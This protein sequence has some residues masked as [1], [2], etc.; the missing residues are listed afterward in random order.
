MSAPLNPP[1]TANA[2]GEFSPR[3]HTTKPARLPRSLRS[4]F[5]TAPF[6][7]TAMATAFA[8]GPFLGAI[9]VQF[10]DPHHKEGVLAFITAISAVGAMVTQPLVGV[11]SDR[12]RGRWGARKP[13]IVAGAIVGIVALL[14]AGLAPS[15]A[16]LTLGI[17]GV[18]VGFNML[19]APFTALLPD[20]VP[21]RFRGRYSSLFGLGAVLG[22]TLGPVVG[23]AFVGQIFLGYLTVA[24]FV[25]LSVL[26]FVLLVP[27]RVKEETDEAV[28][29]HRRSKLKIRDVFAAFWVSPVKY[30]DFFW[31]FLNRI[32]LFSAVTMTSTYGLYILQEYIGLSLDAA[33]QLLALMGVISLPV[34]LVVTAVAGPLSDKVGRRKPIVLIAGILIFVGAALPMIVPNPVVF[35]V[36]GTLNTAG[37]AAFLSTDQA[38]VSQVL[39]PR[40][41]FGKDLGVLNIAATLPNVIAPVVAALIV[42]VFG[43][44]FALYPVVAIIGLAGALCVIPIRGAK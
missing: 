33:A 22:A 15:V 37:F 29:T 28:E 9:Q 43:S 23:A 38:L 7:S 5:G 42:S 19:S 36:A 10:F 3:L 20:R 17:V 4:L 13:W 40:G 25:A 41:T 27:S 18:Q 14:T 31:A 35:A 11:L 12:T 2:V 1:P 44:Y 32:L 24:G 16:I 8:I 30:P 21:I 6:V 26:V 34:I 39:P